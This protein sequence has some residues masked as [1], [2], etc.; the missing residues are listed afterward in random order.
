MPSRMCGKP[1]CGHHQQSRF[2]S[3]SK[4]HSIAL[5]ETMEVDRVLDHLQGKSRGPTVVF[6]GGIHGNEPAG[7]FALRHVFQEIRSKHI[8]IHGEVY[9][10][11][12]NLGALE[13]LDAWKALKGILGGGEEPATA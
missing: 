4:V 5:D 3:M 11:T 2:V 13:Q 12:G 1:Y 6:F 9:A 8:P 7:V 10:I